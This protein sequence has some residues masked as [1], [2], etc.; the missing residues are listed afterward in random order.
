[1]LPDRL[2]Q[3]RNQ[4]QAEATAAKRSSKHTQ[5]PTLNTQQAKACQQQ[6]NQQQLVSTAALSSN[7][8]FLKH[9]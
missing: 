9:K 3:Q 1:M 4:Q 5:A 2:K 8:P 7:S 6:R